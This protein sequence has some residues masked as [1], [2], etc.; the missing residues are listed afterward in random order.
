LSTYNPPKEVKDSNNSE[1]R[2][3]IKPRGKK[4]LSDI[5][6]GIMGGVQEALFDPTKGNTWS[7]LAEDLFSL[8]DPFGEVE[9]LTLNVRISDLGAV[10]A[11]K[12]LESLGFRYQSFFIGKNGAYFSFQKLSGKLFDELKNLK[13]EQGL[14]ILISK[15]FAGVPFENLPVAVQF[16][17]SEMSTLLDS[18]YE[19]VFKNLAEPLAKC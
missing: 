1:K 2:K 10:E 13:K 17:F 12:F 3:S 16:A 7:Q 15:V 11:I 6:G 9:H 18:S 5:I 4:I 19:S 14:E 8:E